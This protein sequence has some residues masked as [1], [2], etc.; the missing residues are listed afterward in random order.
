M[1]FI[2]RE[3]DEATDEHEGYI[4]GRYR[5]GALSDIW[6]DVTRCAQGTFTALVPACECGWRGLPQRPDRR[7][8]DRCWSAW[9]TEHF[10]RLAVARP[11]VALRPMGPDDFLPPSSGPCD[12]E[13][14]LVRTNGGAGSA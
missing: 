4:A 3:A 7:G 8:V 6:T 14:E 10:V 5:N 9:F 11:V 1:L 12:S 2:G 13:R